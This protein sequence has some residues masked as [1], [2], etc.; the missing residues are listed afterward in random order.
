M[1]T[2]AE[3]EDDGDEGAAPGS[4]PWAKATKGRP[5]EW[6]GTSYS[7]GTMEGVRMTTVMALAAR[8]SEGRRGAARGRGN[9]AS[10]G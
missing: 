4:I 9:E 6:M 1:V 3:D 10:W 5:A 7:A 2:I 8:C